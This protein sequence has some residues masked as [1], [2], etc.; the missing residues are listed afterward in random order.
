MLRE[1]PYSFLLLIFI[2]LLLTIEPASALLTISGAS[3]IQP[4]LQALA[5]LYLDTYGRELQITGGGSGA[6]IRMV[7]DGSV[8]LGMVSRALSAEEREDLQHTSIGMD[9]LVIIVNTSNPIHRID[10]DQLTQI[11][12]RRIDNWSQLG[13]EDLPIVLVTK[14]VG[15]STLDLFEG[16]TSLQSPSRLGTS[17]RNRISNEAYE[18]GS[19]LECLTIVGGLPGAM[20]YVSYGS[21]QSMIDQGLPVRILQLD[22]IQAERQTLLQGDYPILRELN[23][24]YQE[25][26]QGIEDL[27]NL[28]GS[29]QGERQIEAEGFIPTGVGRP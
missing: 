1:R 14:E 6:G 23:L 15:R 13:G 5:P 28:L 22:G 8:H 20:G 21:A 24:V 26:D 12:Q 11:Y 7:R 4:I 10:R 19:N 16:Y 3:T 17:T 25:I 29:P 9:A 27:F 18:I 2:L